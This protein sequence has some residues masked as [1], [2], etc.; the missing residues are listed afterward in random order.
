MQIKQNN[1]NLDSRIG[2]DHLDTALSAGVGLGATC[3]QDV[4]IESP[5]GTP[6]VLDLVVVLAT[7]GVSTITNGE[8]TV[9]EL[10]ATS[11]VHYTTLV[12]LEDVLVSLYSDGDGLLHNGSLEGNLGVGRY[13][14]EAADGGCD[15]LASCNASAISGSVRVCSLGGDTLVVNDVLETIVHQTT[16]ATLVTLSARAVNELLLGKRRESA[17]GDKSCTLSGTSGGESPA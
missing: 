11:A 12:E 16:V 4:T 5:V 14:S 6:R 17:S 15:G 13:I 3:E 7:G 1:S 10:G 8:N 2:C 9:V